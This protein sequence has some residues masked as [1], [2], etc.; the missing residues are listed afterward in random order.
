MN[1]TLH[2]NTWSTLHSPLSVTEETLQTKGWAIVSKQIPTIHSR[3]TNTVTNC[4]VGSA[5]NPKRFPLLGGLIM[6]ASLLLV[7]QQ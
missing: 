7:P 1:G 3:C 5:P 6:P 4:L 2:E